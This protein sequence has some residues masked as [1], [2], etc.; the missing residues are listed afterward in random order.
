VIPSTVESI[1][2]LSGIK[3][4]KNVQFYTKILCNTC[5][6]QSQCQSHLRKTTPKKSPQAARQIEGGNYTNLLHHAS[7]LHCILLQYYFKSDTPSSLT[8][9]TMHRVSLPSDA[10]P[11]TSNNS[12]WKHSS[13]SGFCEA[14][15][16]RFIH[17]C[18]LRN[19][20][21]LS[22]RGRERTRKSL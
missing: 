5:I 10:P 9:V 21:G 16:Q 12:I 4:H 7:T 15:I 20:C 11:S 13:L 6:Q 19:S 14:N 3:L 22:G 8:I 1:R 2:T 18:S 17:C